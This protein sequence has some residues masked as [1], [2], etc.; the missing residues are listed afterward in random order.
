MSSILNGASHPTHEVHL[1]QEALTLKESLSRTLE[2]YYI[3]DL[4]LSP[5]FSFQKYKFNIL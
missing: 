4:C 3:Q 5:F 1:T 2:M